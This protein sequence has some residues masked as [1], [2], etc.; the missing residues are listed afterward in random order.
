MPNN[1]Q[2]IRQKVDRQA[3]MHGGWQGS[4]HSDIELFEE[5]SKFYFMETIFLSYDILN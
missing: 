2:V 1:W 4:G 3:E 5:K